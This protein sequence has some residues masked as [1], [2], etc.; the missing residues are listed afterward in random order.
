M[1][2]HTVAVLG[3][4]SVLGFTLIAMGATGRT[5]SRACFALGVAVPIT[6]LAALSAT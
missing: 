1:T 4:L 6:L 2:W 5:S 3:L